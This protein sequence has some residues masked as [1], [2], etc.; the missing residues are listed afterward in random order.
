MLSLILQN[1]DKPLVMRSIQ[2]IILSF[3]L[4]YLP[5]IT[6]AQTHNA[7]GFESWNGP[8]VIDNGQKLENAWAGGLNNVQFGVMDFNGDGY[9]DLLVFDRHGDRLL[10]F[11]F[12]ADNEPDSYRYAPE[13]RRY[14]PEIKQWFQVLDYNDDG[15][16]DIFTYTPGGIMVYRNIGHELP[17][18]IQAV[19]PYITSLQGSIFTNLLVTYVDYPAILDL[20]GDGDL[21]ILTFWGLGSYVDLHKNMSM[22]LY[23]NADSLVFHKI[24]GCWGRF[25]ENPESN[26]IYLDTCYMK[27][28][29]DD[30]KHTG[31]T[32]CMI[33][34]NGDGVKDLIIGD[35]DYSE[36]AFLI[37]GGDD[38]NALMVGQWSQ[39]PE[40][41]SIDLWSFPL[42][43]HL[44]IG[45]KGKKSLLVSSFDP[46]LKKSR[47]YKSVHLYEDV[48]TNETPDFKL[49]TQSFLQNTMIDAGNGAFPV[50]V[51]ING[52]GLTDL[53]LGNYGNF[54]TCVFN[55]NMQLKCSYTGRLKLYINTGDA[56]NPAFTLVDDD[57][58]EVSQLGLLGVYPAFADL[59]GNGSLDMLLGN[60]EG[61]LW[62]FK[63]LAGAGEIPVYDQ[64]LPN[65]QAINV[66]ANSTP[67]FV[68]FPDQTAQS[69]VIGNAEGKLHLFHNIGTAANPAFDLVSD[70]FGEVNVTDPM[71]SYTGHS[72]PC[73]FADAEGKLNLLVGSETGFLHHYTQIISSP[74]AVFKLES[75]HF[76][77]LTEGIRTAPAVTDLNNDGFVDLAIG[78]YSGGITLF[79]GKTP[80]PFGINGNGPAKQVFSIY[81]NPS[82]GEFEVKFS[83]SG[84]WM[85]RIIDARGSIVKQQETKG[86]TKVHFDIQN[87]PSGLYYI[88]AFN[89]TKGGEAGTGKLVL[90]R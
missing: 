64:P 27:S 20:D 7:F 13:F 8:E 87:A 65:F 35:V 45:N 2:L 17:E 71:L 21:D 49:Q 11:V 39:F 69:L 86:T 51:D 61:N 40:N 29:D 73:F 79:K 9:D 70:F 19:D 66:G 44:D 54:D 14:F 58:A 42:V 84:D 30:P 43:Q 50:F 15:L 37:N 36:P 88:L 62:Y 34:I 55:D 85:V 31:S 48:S 41:E 82:G 26:V 68:K 75:K 72:V 53:V 83:T 56:S 12:L 52:D 23:G 78:N 57:F 46:G 28:A 60:T 76:M 10:P 3:V 18:F 5:F 59:D 16:P 81:P 89:T 6:C 90:I 38:F 47:G 24:E 74:G 77:Y 67:V 32:F 63:N 4:L 33:D 1:F 22:E 25:A 80:D